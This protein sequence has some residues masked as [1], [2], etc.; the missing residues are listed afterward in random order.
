MCLEILSMVYAGAISEAFK[1]A[2]LDNI[3]T[4]TRHL[5]PNDTFPKSPVPNETRHNWEHCQM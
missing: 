2:L 4:P 5:T 3:N 1:E